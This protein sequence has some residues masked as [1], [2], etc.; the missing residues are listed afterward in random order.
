MKKEIWKD[1]PG[2]ETKYQVS[3][4]GRVRSL[5][6]IWVQTAASGRLHLHRKKGLI[7][8]PGLNA[9]GY[10]TVVLGRKYGSATVH[11]LVA[12]AFLGIPAAWQQVRHLNNRRNDPRLENLCYGTRLDNLKDSV[13]HG[14]FACRYE[15][16]RHLSIK[17]V[18]DIIVEYG[19]GGVTQKA[20]AERYS[21]APGTIGRAIRREY[22]SYRLGN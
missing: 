8:R 5:D 11:S 13:R 9:Q 4:M 1:I 7:L 20:L 2:F 15:K 22:S 3:N 19:K 14:T 16:Q 12:K 10:P 21:V 6:Q 18:A 17:Q